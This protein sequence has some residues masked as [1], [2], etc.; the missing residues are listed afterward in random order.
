METVELRPL[1]LGELLDRTFS[2]Y[3]SHFWLFVG[4]T[5][6][7]AIF[8]IPERILLYNMQGSL[9]NMTPGAPPTLPTLGLLGR[10]FLGEFAFS[11]VFGL[12][13]AVGMGAATSAVAHSYLGRPSTVRGSYAEIRA[14][15]WRLIGVALNVAL[16]V[17]GIILLPI[18]AVGGGLITAVVAANGWSANNPVAVLL[19]LAT[20]GFFY[21]A[22]LVLC[23]WF[24][25]RY[26]VVIP[27]LMIEDLG[28]LDTIRRSVRLTR[29]RRGQIFLALLVAAIIVYVGLFVF[30]MP[31][32]ILTMMAALKGHLPLWLSS[33]SGVASA[34]GIAVAGPISMIVTVL[35][36]Y[37]TRIR[38]E[39]FDLQHMMSSLERPGPAAGTVSPA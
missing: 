27:V 32:A 11:F 33:A 18:V 19:I 29:G 31:F 30:Q 5:T 22:A 25:L 21:L 7:P 15:F 34:F 6:I 8:V 35:L 3:R 13:Y 1:S 2:L 14:K 4:I 24:A 38:K 23:V 36:Y 12:V 28:V 39:A 37:D 17:L 20:F 26:A 9:F 10:L 16:R